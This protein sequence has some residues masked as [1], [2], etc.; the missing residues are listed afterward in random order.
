MTNE[1][2]EKLEEYAYHDAVDELVQAAGYNDG[3]WNMRFLVELDKRGLRLMPGQARYL[4]YVYAPDPVANE[5]PTWPK[6]CLIVP[7]RT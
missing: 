4:Y 7:R 3:S 2:Q 6:Q 5:A 1:E